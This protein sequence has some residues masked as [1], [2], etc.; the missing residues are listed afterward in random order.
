MRTWKQIVVLVMGQDG[1]QV[2]AEEVKVILGLRF[3]GVERARQGRSRSH[4]KHITEE[5]L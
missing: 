5:L 1:S 3:K 2:G 4:D